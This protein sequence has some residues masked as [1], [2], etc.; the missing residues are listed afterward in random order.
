MNRKIYIKNR[1][2]YQNRI[3]HILNYI[4]VKNASVLDLACGEMILYKM[5]GHTMKT[6]LGIDQFNY[7]DHPSFIQADIFDNTEV[8]NLDV[9]I[10]FLLGVLDHLEYNQ[11]IKLL[12]K[13]KQLFAKTLVISQFNDAA[14]FFK[15]RNAIKAPVN[16]NTYFQK[17]TIQSIYLFKLP[18]L[19]CVWDVTNAP[20]WI[21]KN[22]TERVSIISKES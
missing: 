1:R 22:C 18:V 5:E 9:D 16:L 15:K 12:E 13:Y 7:Q 21:K 4:S 11:K 6:Y 8:V 17:M 20:N 19:P 10:I 14:W 2:Y 3:R